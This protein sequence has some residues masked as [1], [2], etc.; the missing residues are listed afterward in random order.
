MEFVLDLIINLIT[1]LN[2]IG[3]SWI[4]KS[5]RR[6]LNKVIAIT[7]IVGMSIVGIGFFISSSD[8]VHFYHYIELGISCG[9]T[10]V[11]LIFNLL[12]KKFGESTLLIMCVWLLSILNLVAY[13]VYVVLT[14][15]SY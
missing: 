4:L 11:L 14:F 3:I 13:I 1:L 12:I 9:I 7:N 6:N 10:V 15:I 2:F 5:D 8:S